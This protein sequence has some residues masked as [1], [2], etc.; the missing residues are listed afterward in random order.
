MVDQ[1][2]EVK[3]EEVVKTVES[4]T[5]DVKNLTEAVAQIKRNKDNFV[6][7]DVL[8]RR[9]QELISEGYRPI[10]PKMK[11]EEVEEFWQI[12]DRELQYKYRMENRTADSKIEHYEAEVAL[13]I[14]YLE[15]AKAELEVMESG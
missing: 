13:A 6:D 10:Q 8:A 3:V 1:E 11:F 7:Q 14:T 15:E 5:E 12:M 4:L 2:S 9:K